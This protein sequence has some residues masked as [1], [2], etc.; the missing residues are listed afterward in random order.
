MVMRS[1]LII[2][3]SLF[4]FDVLFTQ[5]IGSTFLEFHSA[6]QNKNYNFLEKHLDDKIIYTHSNAWVENKNSIISNL[7][8]GYMNYQNILI[9]SVQVNRFGNIA[10]IKAKANIQGV[11]NQNGF[12]IKLLILQTWKKKYFGQWKLISRSA[13]KTN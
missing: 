11:V 6:L 9:D 13:V 3:F 4:S 10:I 7:Q 1:S 2:L 8:S 12:D 5:S